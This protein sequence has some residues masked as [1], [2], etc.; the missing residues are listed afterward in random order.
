MPDVTPR[1]RSEIF[2]LRRMR[3]SSAFLTA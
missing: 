3:T 2:G 1:D